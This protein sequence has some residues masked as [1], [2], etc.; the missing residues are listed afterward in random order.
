MDVSISDVLNLITKNGSQTEFV[1]HLPFYAKTQKK[2]NDNIAFEEHIQELEL[3]VRS[4]NDTSHL[5]QKL[6]TLKYLG[7]KNPDLKAKYDEIER[8]IM[9][10]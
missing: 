10:L 7:L 9:S 2:K 1:F 4:I 3:F 5:A 8:Q 6:A